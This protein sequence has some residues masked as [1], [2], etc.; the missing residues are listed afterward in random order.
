MR[1]LPVLPSF[2]QLRLVPDK[3]KQLNAA[4]DVD[5]VAAESNFNFF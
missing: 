5:A 2:R 3:E 4:K 1:D